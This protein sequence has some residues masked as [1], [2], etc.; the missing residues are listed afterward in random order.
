MNDI[1]ADVHRRQHERYLR[2]EAQR[3]WEAERPRRI[4]GY[5]ITGVQLVIVSIIFYVFLF[6]GALWASM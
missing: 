4:L 2:R 6:A 3:R 5:L 1:Y